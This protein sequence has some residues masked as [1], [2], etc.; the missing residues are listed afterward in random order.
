MP[1]IVSLESVMLGS[2]RQVEGWARITVGASIASLGLFFHYQRHFRYYPTPLRHEAV[3]GLRAPPYCH[4]GYHDSLRL[5]TPPYCHYHD[6]FRLRTPPYC[7]YHD[8]FRLRTPPYCHYHDSFRLKTP[9]YC[10]YHDSFRLRTPPYCHYHDSFRL[11]TP[12]YCHYHDSL[13]PS[14]FCLLLFSLRIFLI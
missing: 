14:I 9:P 1:V 11:R 3:G 6:S 2:L 13:S 7:H 8:S 5:R 12:P 4:Y 10:H